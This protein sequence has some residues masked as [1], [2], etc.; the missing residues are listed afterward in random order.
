MIVLSNIL[1]IAVLVALMFTWFHRSAI[2]GGATGGLIIGGV[3]GLFTGDIF[4]GIKNGVIIGGV[5]GIIAEALG[6]IGDRI[7]RK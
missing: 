2:W 7:R 4:L 1:L 6:M 3:I 5:I